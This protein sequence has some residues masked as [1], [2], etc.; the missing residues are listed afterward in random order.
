M[1]SLLW[2]SLLGCRSVDADF[3]ADVEVQRAEIERFNVQTMA[4]LGG[5]LYGRGELVVESVQGDVFF[6]PLEVRGGTFGFGLDLLPLGAVGR[7]TLELP[8]RRVMGNELFGRYKGS[9]MSIVA[10]LGAEVRHMRNEF[11]VGID[12]ASFGLGVGLMAAHDWLTLRPTIDT[13]VGRPTGDTGDVDDVW[14]VP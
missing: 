6:V 1:V 14:E 8:D 12:E 7:A 2:L 13:L 3:L 10:P 5:A 11:G 9:S 4:V